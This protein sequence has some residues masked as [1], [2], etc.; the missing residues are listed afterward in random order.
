MKV[1]IRSN[2]AISGTTD[3]VV[4]VDRTI[5]PWTIPIVAAFLDDDDIQEMVICSGNTGF[6]KTFTKQR[7]QGAT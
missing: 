6:V 7:P 2:S 1:R 5:P 4:E 3:S